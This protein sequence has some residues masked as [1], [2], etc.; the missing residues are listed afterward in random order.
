MA[1]VFEYK[2]GDI[3]G[4]LMLTGKSYM[5]LYGGQNRRFIEVICDCGNIFFS[6][7]SSIIEG[8][9]K[10]CGCKKRAHLIDMNTTH[11]MCV[12]NNVHP[13]YITWQA[14]IQ[15]CTNPNNESAIH[16]S[17]K[18]IIVCKEWR[19]SFDSFYNWSLVNGWV[20][21]LSID[22]INNDG[23]YEPSNCRWATRYQQARN[24][25]NSDFITA[26]GETKCF[27]DWRI[28]ERCV[29]GHGTL[30]Y[31]LK[32]LKWNPERAITQLPKSPFFEYNK[33]KKNV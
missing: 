19:D 10:S 27:S 5:K 6:Y 23:N 9:V 18:G 12:E 2:A 28:D 22:R 17:K 4:N 3:Y 30:F 1:K 14:M 7:Y 13:I 26:F 8:K 16:Y 25:S 20:E 15:R 31:R 21:G 11:G 33:N 24:K 32:K 29:V